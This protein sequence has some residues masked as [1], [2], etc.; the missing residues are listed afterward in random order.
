MQ[1]ILALVQKLGPQRL[2]AMGAV[3]LSLV[4]FFAF[5]M[6]R[7]SQPAMGLLFTDLSPSESAAII[8]ELDGRGLRSELRNDGATVL[9][10]RD[11][12]ARIRMDLAA[13]GLPAGGGIGFEI[14]DKGDSFS[15][16]SFVQNINQVRALEGELSRSIRSLDRV[17]NAR[18]HLAIPERRLFQKERAEP[19]AS[20]VLKVRGELDAAQVRAI[21]HLVATAVDGLKPGRISL[22]DE[23]GRLLADGAGDE[24]DV[25]AAALD[26][27]Q[28]HERRLQKQVEDIVASVVGRGRARVQVAADYELNRIQQ[29]AETFDPESRVVRST[30]NRTETNSSTEGRDGQVTVAN[31]QPGTQKSEAGGSPSREQ[32]QKNEEV[33]NYEISRTTRTEVIEPGRLKRLSVAVLVD[34]LYSKGANGALTYAPRQAEELQRIATLV[35]LGI[36]FNKE[37]G[38]QVE[39]VNLP[40]AEAPQA[41]D[42]A[43][44]PLLERLLAFS[45]DDLMRLSEAGVLLLTT[46]IVLIFVVRPLIRQVLAP[47]VT[48]RTA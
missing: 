47:P 36:G 34:G 37:R 13:K 3:T 33:T 35:R 25:S 39:V 15:A 46:L 1:T 9:V 6:L 10:P 38:D 44:P 26:R 31:E 8:K 16:T 27:Q 29:T 30:Q 24:A 41:A 45:R 20:I 23:A 32:G 18:V 48:G 43:E 12:L 40:F 14:F 42:L 19:R 11:N 2:A 28:M 4:G 22:V 21:R 17:Q 7:L 5:V